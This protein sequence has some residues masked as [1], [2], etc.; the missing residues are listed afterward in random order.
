MIAQVIAQV[1]LYY[2]HNLNYAYI[3]MCLLGMAHP[4]KVVILLTYAVE[5]ME[6]KYQHQCSNLFLLSEMVIIAMISFFYQF[7]SKNWMPLQ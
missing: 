5:V 7:I 6:P 3:F 1:G 2:V 4:G